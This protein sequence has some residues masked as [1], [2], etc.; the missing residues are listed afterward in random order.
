MTSQH[1]NIPE[2]SISIPNSPPE[3]Q[4]QFEEIIRESPVSHKEAD[5]PVIPKTNGFKCV[6]CSMIFDSSYPACPTC[7]WD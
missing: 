3:L 1:Y 5:I 7:N 4:F 6:I 2:K